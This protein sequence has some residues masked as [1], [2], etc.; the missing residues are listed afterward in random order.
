MMKFI[1]KNLLLC[2]EIA[3]LLKK[4]RP[5]IQKAHKLEEDLV[6][7]DKLQNKIIKKMGLN[8]FYTFAL[9]K[10]THTFSNQD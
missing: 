2:E 8:E 5:I 3:V 10:D 1:G 7:F 6:K 4:L 9:Q